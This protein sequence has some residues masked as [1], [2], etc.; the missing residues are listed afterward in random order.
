MHSFTKRNNKNNK[1]NNFIHTKKNRLPYK[2]KYSI[3]KL[4]KNSFL[5]ASKS[6]HGQDLLDYTFKNEHVMKKTCI[7][8]NINWFGNYQVAKQYLTHQNH[9]YKWILKKN[10]SLLITNKKNYSFFRS[11]FLNNTKFQLESSISITK[12][13]TINHPYLSMNSNERAFYEF[14]F[15]FGYLT[16]QEQYEFMNFLKYLLENNIIR[17]KTRD[18][19]S[20]LKK[21]VIKMYYFRIRHFFYQKKE[22][23]RLSFYELDKHAILNICKLIKANHLP[24]AGIF[25]ENNDSFWF[26]NLIFYKMNIEEI[27]LFQPH[28][29]LLFDT[30]VE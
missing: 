24:I 23:N 9:L 12:K 4:L 3:K 2:K 26:P 1:N 18:G 6:V 29:Y 11:L 7:L 10:A 5:Y 28:H 16:I 15:V 25:Q 14:C 21:L 8:N 19:K 17:M 22:N 27:I 13:V 20:I 30:L